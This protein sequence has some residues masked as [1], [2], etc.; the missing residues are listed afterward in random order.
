MAVLEELAQLLKSNPAI[1][2]EIGGHTDDAGDPKVNMKLSQDRADEVKKQLVAIGIDPGRLTAQGFGS[3]KPLQ[4][5]A[6]AEGRAANRR[7]EFTKQ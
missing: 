7:V 1:K 4:S 3:S 2:L 6:T 5:N